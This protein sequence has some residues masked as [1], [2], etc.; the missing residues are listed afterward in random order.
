ME[1]TIYK[2][3]DG[4]PV[5]LD[6][7][8]DVAEQ[9]GLMYADLGEFMLT[10]NGTLVLSD[11]CGNYMPIMKEGKYIIDICLEAQGTIVKILY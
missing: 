6:E 11:N 5:N 4:Y 9:H 3:S 2:K 7:F 1:F 8:V 10:E